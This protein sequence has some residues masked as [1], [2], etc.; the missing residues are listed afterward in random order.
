MDNL[1]PHRAAAIGELL[2]QAEIG[3]IYR[4]HPQ[5]TAESPVVAC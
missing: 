2:A 3:L 1:R 5:E 4:K